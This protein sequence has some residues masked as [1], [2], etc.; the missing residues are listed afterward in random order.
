MSKPASES[1]PASERMSDS[2]EEGQGIGHTLARWLRSLVD[3]GIDGVGPFSGSAALAEAVRRD[4]R[5]STTEERVSALI[6]NE[7]WKGFTTGFLTGFPGLTAVL[8]LMPASM[9]SAIMLQARLAGAVA[10]LHGY[11]LDDERVRTFV[12]LSLTG[13]V[14]REGVKRVTAMVGKSVALGA[15]R[16]VPGRLIFAINRKIGFR[17]LTKFGSRG[18]INL[19]RLVP[20][21]GGLVG[22]VVDS[23]ATRTVGR[24]AQH[25]FRSPDLLTEPFDLLYADAEAEVARASAAGRVSAT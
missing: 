5:Y 20:L 17:L 23:I 3:K 6:S 24:S 10:H 1:V 12:F 8:L 25:T 18:L 16:K 21:V 9:V 14:G 4:P 7:A 2:G 13:D 11:S 15:V 22:G 19:S